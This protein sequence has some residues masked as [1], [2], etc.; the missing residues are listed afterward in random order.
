MQAGRG[1][2]P[3]APPVRQRGGAL[4]VFPSTLIKKRPS[5]W[6]A[7]FDMADSVLPTTA[8]G[9][10]GITRGGKQRPF[11][12]FARSARVRGKAAQFSASPRALRA[13]Q[14]RTCL[15]YGNYR[16][17]S[18]D[19]PAEALRPWRGGGRVAV[20]PSVHPWQGAADFGRRPTGGGAGVKE[21]WPQAILIENP[22]HRAGSAKRT[23]AGVAGR[24]ARERPSRVARSRRSPGRPPKPPAASFPHFLSA[25]EMGPPAGAGPGNSAA[26]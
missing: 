19:S 14:K 12:A 20:H 24:S 5:D 10:L 3:P 13:T 23:Q 1:A 8:A 25:Q 6:T 16:Y 9:R 17:G 21:I 4:A 22:A 11:R 15:P 7:S 2:P 18:G 26:H